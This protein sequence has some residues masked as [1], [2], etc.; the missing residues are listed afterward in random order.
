MAD[1]FHGVDGLGGIH[2]SHPHL[3]PEETWKDLFEGSIKSSDAE[4]IEAAK[5]IAHP[6]SSFTP[7]K[8]P[9]HEEM[10]RLLRDNEADSI[11]IVAIG[12][13][14][15]LARAAAVDPETFLRAKEVIVM[16]GAIATPG[17]V[18]PPPL[19]PNPHGI[20]AYPFGL[21]KW[22][23][24]P[25]RAKLNERNQ[26]N[27]V[28]EFNTYADSIA[29]ARVFALTSPYPRSTMPPVPPAPP[30][31]QSSEAPPPFLRPYP[32]KLSRKL[33]LTLF[34]LGLAPYLLADPRC[35]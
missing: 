6:N 16:G 24:S 19:H 11:S 13:L 9:A 4:E 21:T 31:K 2:S 26:I 28:A 29:S 30:G 7:S 14:T 5:E 15:N 1:Y 12:P 23:D 27:P 20:K 17:N 35:E 10:L 25:L 18:P 32:E 22:P 34:P 3:T 33:K 8:L